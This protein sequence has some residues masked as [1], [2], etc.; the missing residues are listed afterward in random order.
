MPPPTCIPP[1]YSYE[2]LD[3]LGELGQGRVHATVGSAL[4]IFGGSLD[5]DELVKT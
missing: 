5:M 1:G 4:D 2:D 3:L